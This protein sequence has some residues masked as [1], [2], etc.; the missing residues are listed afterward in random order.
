MV[1]TYKSMYTF[2]IYRHIFYKRPKIIH[3]HTVGGHTKSLG[4]RTSTLCHDSGANV[5]FSAC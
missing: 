5:L 2:K 3:T 1:E 4:L